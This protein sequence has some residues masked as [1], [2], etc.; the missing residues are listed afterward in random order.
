MKNLECPI[1][2][3]AKPAIASFYLFFERLPVLPVSWM[4]VWKFQ[5]VEW[6][7]V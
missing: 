5:K 6:G 2:Y 4:R 3:P 1:V 7:R